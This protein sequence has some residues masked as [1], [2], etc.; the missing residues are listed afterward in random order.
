M[1]LLIMQVDIEKQVS[2]VVKPA[3]ARLTC[4]PPKVVYTGLIVELKRPT[5][6]ALP[7]DIFCVLL[8]LLYQGQ[9][10]YENND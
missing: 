4:K 1:H 2:R 8:S 3:V 9:S 6:S 10:S 7:P 5:Q